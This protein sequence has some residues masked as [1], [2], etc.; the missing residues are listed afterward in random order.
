MVGWDGVKATNDNDTFIT[1][2]YRIFYGRM[3]E[4]ILAEWVS[5]FWP[6]G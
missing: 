6:N 5:E 4:R 2:T 3:G 1:V